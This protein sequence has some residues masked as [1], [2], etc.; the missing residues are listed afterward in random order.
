MIP[1]SSMKVKRY[2]SG[3]KKIIASFFSIN[4]YC[5]ILQ[6]NLPNLRDQEAL[7]N[8]AKNIPEAP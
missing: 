3:K 1:P 2:R 4:C 8:L 5:A 7:R 6:N